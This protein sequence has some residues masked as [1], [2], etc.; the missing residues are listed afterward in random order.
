MIYFYYPK[1]KNIR[2][3]EIYTYSSIKKP[4]T[5]QYLYRNNINSNNKGTYKNYGLSIL[6]FN[7]IDSLRTQRVYIRV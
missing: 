1:H 3:I 2:T 4:F 5:N 6:P 7:D